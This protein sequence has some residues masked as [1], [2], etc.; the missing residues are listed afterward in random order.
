M[1]RAWDNPEL[2]E[3]DFSRDVWC[4]LGLP[5]DNIT[6]QA[7]V[8]SIDESVKSGCQKHLITPNVN[9]ICQSLSDP[10][11][12]KNLIL[13]ELSLVDG[14]P[15]LWIAR[16][17]GL[18]LNEK[19]SGSD[20]V[21]SLLL[22]TEGQTVKLFIFGGAP[23]VAQNA[24]ARINSC[25]SRVRGVGWCYPGWGSSEELATDDH[26]NQINRVDSDFVAVG[27][28]AQKG[29]RWIKLVRERLTAKI[30]VSLGITP[31]FLAGTVPRAPQ[32]LRQVGLEW[33]WRIVF[34]PYLARRYTSDG[35]VLIR[36]ILQN[37]VPL[38]LLMWNHRDRVDAQDAP[39]IERRSFLDRTEVRIIGTCN[40]VH[41][42]QIRKDLKE[43]VHRDK[44]VVLDLSGVDFLDNS[45][46]GT[47]LLLKKYSLLSGR[48]LRLS[49]LSPLL[50]KILHLNLVRQD[51][52]I[53]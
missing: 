41:R 15:I 26:I 34:Q 28:N 51:F 35:L 17:L 30:M 37:V 44:D 4:L 50:A 53:L 46:L 21:Q 12:R 11:F 43:L 45:F 18:A 47:L 38:R 1:T 7:T 14:V 36:L 5:F 27:L 22:S 48:Q 10:E 19:V 16:F 23:G 6:L 2:V 33:L 39:S 29:T 52:I 42:A 13:N 40:H 31:E 20:L 49:G 25:H 24:A 9:F 32:K 8:T 3:S